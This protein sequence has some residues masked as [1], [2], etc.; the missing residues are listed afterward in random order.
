MCFFWQ[1]HDEARKFSYQTGVKVV[2]AYGG[3]L[4]NQQVSAI[5]RENKRF[6]MLFPDVIILDLCTFPVHHL[7]RFCADSCFSFKLFG[8]IWTKHSYGRFG[9][10]LQRKKDFTRFFI[11]L[12]G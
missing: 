12:N 10:S 6:C 8:N 1:I 2:V 7:V 3:T 11:K 9:N 5:N 4:V